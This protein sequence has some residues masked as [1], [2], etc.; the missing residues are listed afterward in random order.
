M[1]RASS[2]SACSPTAIRRPRATWRLVLD[3]ENSRGASFPAPSRRTS[4]ASSSIPAWSATRSASGHVQCDSIIM[5][6]AKIRSIP[7]IAAN[8]TDAQL[9]HEAAIGKIA[10]DQL[11]K[12]QTLGLDRRGGGGYHPQ[13]LPRVRRHKKGTRLLRSCVPFLCAV[14]LLLN[15]ASA[16]A[17]AGAST[18][19]S[20]ERPRERLR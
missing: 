8:S 13:G 9:I 17:S 5:G 4:P 2:P 16:G 6:S 12:L 20:A 1:P 10:G 11:L 14:H 18:G 19:A 7:E 15:G 3:G